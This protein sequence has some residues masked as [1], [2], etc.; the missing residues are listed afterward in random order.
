MV[1]TRGEA[2]ELFRSFSKR[3]VMP[4]RARRVIRMRVAKRRGCKFRGFL[5]EPATAPAWSNARS[6]L[7]Q[8][9]DTSVLPTQRRGTERERMLGG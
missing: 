5:R 1:Y 8:C 3:R 4:G 2:E 9:T 6:K 7:T